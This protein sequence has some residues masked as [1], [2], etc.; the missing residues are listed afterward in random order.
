[1]YL[2]GSG[3]L[4]VFFHFFIVDVLHEPLKL[5]IDQCLLELVLMGVLGDE[6]RG[7]FLVFFMHKI[8][9]RCYMTKNTVSQI[10]AE[11]SHA[12]RRRHVTFVLKDFAYFHSMAFLGFRKRRFLR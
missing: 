11:L 10:V 3:D 1:L 4:G 2:H 12:H 7:E 9:N 5:G 8:I 6:L